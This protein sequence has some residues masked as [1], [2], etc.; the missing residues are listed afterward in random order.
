MLAATQEKPKCRGNVVAG[1]VLALRA[2]DI[3]GWKKGLATKREEEG[4]EEFPW[5]LGHR[6]DE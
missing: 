5:D 4:M 6:F 3:G 2:G 1:A